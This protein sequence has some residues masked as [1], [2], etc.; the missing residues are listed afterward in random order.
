MHGG[1]NRGFKLSTIKSGWKRKF[2]ADA[3]AIALRALVRV[4][5][6]EVRIARFSSCYIPPK[7][8][9]KARQPKKLQRLG[10]LW[11]H[12]PDTNSLHS[13]LGQLSRSHATSKLEEA[14]FFLGASR[15]FWIVLASCL[16]ACLVSFFAS[17]AAV[18]LQTRRRGLRSVDDGSG[19]DSESASHSELLD[20]LL[21]KPAANPGFVQRVLFKADFYGGTF[22]FNADLALRCSVVT[23][24]CAGDLLLRVALLVAGAGLGDELR[25]G[26]PRI[27]LLPGL[28]DYKLPGM[29]RFLWDAPAGGELL[30]YVWDVSIRG[31]GR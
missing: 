27:L 29:D 30:V 20:P 12:M 2:H 9:P 1:K 22:A 15:D 21:E 25:R 10:P 19:S 8:W 6:G 17:F 3:V 14:G 11:P 4:L 24:F 16:A 18:E 5:W 28:R 26:D 31:E 7:I 23:L 13:G